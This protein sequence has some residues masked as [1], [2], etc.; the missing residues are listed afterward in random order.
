[1][2]EENRPHHQQMAQQLAELV[3]SLASEDYTLKQELLHREISGR[4]KA[5]AHRHST[6]SDPK[7]RDRIVELVES[8][9][10]SASYHVPLSQ[11]MDK[12][13]LGRE[14]GRGFIGILEGAALNGLIIGND[15]IVIVRSAA[16][17]L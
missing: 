13:M 6:M 17:S 10:E 7:I 11:S 9:D 14:M 12:M 16:R 4:L 1:M 15:G 2:T 8:F 5:I 3:D